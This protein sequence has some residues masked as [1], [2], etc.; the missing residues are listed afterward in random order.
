MVG[1]TLNQT[2]RGFAAVRRRVHVLPLAPSR[3][4][5]SHQR[6]APFHMIWMPMQ[7]RMKAESRTRTLAPRAPKAAM[8]RSA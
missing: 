4:P 7:S 3:L 1:S 5:D 2:G 8:M 6:L